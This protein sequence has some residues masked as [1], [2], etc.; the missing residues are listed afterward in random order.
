MVDLRRKNEYPINDYDGQLL[1][2]PR[3]IYYLQN[4]RFQHANYIENH[5]LDIATP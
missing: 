5:I 2:Y 1:R 4:Q 3:L